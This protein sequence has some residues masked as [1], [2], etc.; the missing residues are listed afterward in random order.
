MVFPRCGSQASKN[1]EAVC[2]LAVS[3]FISSVGM[4][5]SP[6]TLLWAQMLEFT[7][8]TKTVPESHLIA[9]VITT[10]FLIHLLY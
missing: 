2:F 8:A 6:L 10:S 7:L 5:G 1:K 3:I 4:S 9:S